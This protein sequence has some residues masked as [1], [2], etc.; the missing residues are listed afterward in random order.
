MVLELK[1]PE[2][3]TWQ[4]LLDKQAIFESYL[5]S[6][7]MVWIYWNN[8]HHL[9]QSVKKINGKVLLANGHLLFWLSLMPFVTGWMGHFFEPLPVAVFGFVLLMAGVAYFIL[10]RVLIQLH[11]QDSSLSRAIGKDKKGIISLL[12]YSTA[13]GLAYFL[14]SVSCFIYVA[15]AIMWLI[16]D[17]RIEDFIEEFE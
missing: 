1:T 15:I 9:F 6:F 10:T 14:P 2:N 3:G 13:I 16:P 11:G 7:V 12:G 17:K 5:L 8:H 4:A